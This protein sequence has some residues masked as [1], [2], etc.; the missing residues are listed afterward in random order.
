M[1]KGLNAADRKKILQNAIAAVNKKHPGVIVDPNNLP[2][3]DT[4]S[5]RKL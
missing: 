5:S 2:V 1:S 4:I 3:L